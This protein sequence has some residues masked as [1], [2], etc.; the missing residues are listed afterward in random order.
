MHV[1]GH[2]KYYVWF[3]CV[4]FL[5]DSPNITDINKTNTLQN[6]HTIRAG[7]SHR[8]NLQ[9]WDPLIMGFAT[10][11]WTSS[12]RMWNKYK[13]VCKIA[14]FH[15]HRFDQE[16]DRR[17]TSLPYRVKGRLLKLQYS[18]VSI[19]LSLT[20][21][22]L[23]HTLYVNVMTHIHYFKYRIFDIIQILRFRVDS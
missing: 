3:F 13:Y 18:L 7:T 16:S 1:P 10:G 17:L 6:L 23:K 2:C 12:K 14:C 19:E 11:Q 8:D 20:F 15:Y 21:R 4:F 9:L 22:D 5:Q